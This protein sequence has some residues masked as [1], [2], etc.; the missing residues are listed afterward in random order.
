MMVKQMTGSKPEPPAIQ[1][2]DGRQQE[3]NEDIC[4]AFTKKLEDQ[5][6]ISEEENQDFNQQFEIEIKQEHYLNLPHPPTIINTNRLKYQGQDRQFDIFDLTAVLNAMKEEAPGPSGITRTYLREIPLEL[7][8]LTY[9]M[10][11]SV[12]DTSHFPGKQLGW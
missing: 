8:W 4:K 12:L 1:D 10:Q 7:A 2:V 9:T 11:H 6:R 5:F 3:T